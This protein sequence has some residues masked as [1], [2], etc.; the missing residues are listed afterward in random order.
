ML[1]LLVCG[2]IWV[3]CGSLKETVLYSYEFCMLEG[4]TYFGLKKVKL[5]PDP[6][7]DNLDNSFLKYREAPVWC[8]FSGSIGLSSNGIPE[9]TCH[10]PTQARWDFLFQQ[11]KPLT[12]I[13]G[14]SDFVRDRQI[15]FFLLFTAQFS[16]C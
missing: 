1:I 10:D 3:L 7:L 6:L 14:L 9:C 11:K 2:V 4:E 12:V 8:A 16:H 13:L 5:Q 15:F